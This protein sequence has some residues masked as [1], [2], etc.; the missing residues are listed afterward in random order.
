M[1]F[2]KKKP[3]FSKSD[4]M[5]LALSENDYTTVLEKSDF[6]NREILLTSINPTIADNIDRVIRFWNDVDEQEGEL[7]SNN[8]RTPIKIYIDCVGGGSLTGM[9]TIIDAIKMSKTP[10]YTINIGSTYKEA[11]FVYL[12]GHKRYSYP[13]ASFL[14]K[15]DLKPFNMDED[16][17]SNYVNFCDKQMQELKD[18]L[19]NNTKINENEYEKRN[20]WWLDAEKAKELNICHEVNR[21][22]TI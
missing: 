5:R 9:F 18:M 10:V 17:E 11:L 21:T 4:L 3:S 2:I 19:M 14:Y 1:N 6:V 20:T 15:K 12:A 16:A 8:A 13:R 22:R 7:V